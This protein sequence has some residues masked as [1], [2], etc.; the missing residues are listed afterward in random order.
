MMLLV[1]LVLF[2]GAV[3]Y[4][5]IRCSAR[6]NKST[7]WWSESQIFSSWK[8][9][10]LNPTNPPVKSVLSP[11]VCHWTLIIR[12]QTWHLLRCYFNPWLTN[13]DAQVRKVLAADLFP[14]QQGPVDL[15]YWLRMKIS[16]D[17]LKKTPTHTYSVWACRLVLAHTVHV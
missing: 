4:R 7:V 17:L 3:E 14:W 6:E 16:V 5:R 9:L 1:L 15:S 10:I 8:G 2:V 12:Q 11:P 13:T